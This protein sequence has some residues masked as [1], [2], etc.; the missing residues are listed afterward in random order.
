MKKQIFLLLLIT[1]L[2]TVT[3]N[4]FAVDLNDRPVVQSRISYFSNRVPIDHPRL[5]L[6]K[7][8]LPEFQAFVKTM[9]AKNEYPKVF[10]DVILEPANLP[11]PAEPLA[12]N[13]KINDNEQRS[14]WRNGYTTAFKTASKAQQY[15]FSYLYTG[16][17]RY[18][19]EFA[20]WLV[21]LSGWN[22]NGGINIKTNDE[23]FIQSLRPMLFA[24]DWAYDA[25]TEQEKAFILKHLK[26]RLEILYQSITNRFNLTKA[27]P[28][29]NSLSHPMRFI[30]TLGIGGLVLYQDLP[31]APTYLAWAYEYYLRQ[32]PVW[33]GDDGGWSEGLDYWRSGTNQHFLF[34]DAMK[35][36]NSSEIFNKKFFRHNGYFPL[37]NLEPYRTSLAN[38]LLI[39]GQLLK[40]RDFLVSATAPINIE[41]KFQPGSLKI[42]IEVKNKTEIRIKLPFQPKR[43]DKIAFKDWQYTPDDRMLRLNVTES[44]VL[45]VE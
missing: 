18:G 44:A 12:P 40:S 34:Y 35:A 37:Y 3:I 38:F 5:L 16:D 41:G 26:A 32:F 9:I 7:N 21:H 11:L 39:D 15:A 42:S 8:E 25:L 29:G 36:L 22:I 17:L 14:I 6:L 10:K 30:S 4:S 43:I 20:R 13:L 31:E 27:V 45:T 1:I 33:G 2:L 24:Y 28:P 23:A 19:R